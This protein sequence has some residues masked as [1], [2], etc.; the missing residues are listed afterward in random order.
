MPSVSS[1]SSGKYLLNIIFR[2][3]EPYYRTIIIRTWMIHGKLSLGGDHV[4]V[5]HD[6]THAQTIQK[7]SIN[8]RPPHPVFLRTYSSGSF[9]RNWPSLAFLQM[10]LLQIQS[11]IV[12]LPRYYREHSCPTGSFEDV[13]RVFLG[14]WLKDAWRTCQRG[15]WFVWWI[16][17]YVVFNIIG[18]SVS[19]G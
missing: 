16:I 5:P 13:W 14:V 8:T 18:F 10:P 3:A 6:P 2:G 4:L 19:F 15:E 11:M 12:A 17:Y 1:W 9:Y 7:K